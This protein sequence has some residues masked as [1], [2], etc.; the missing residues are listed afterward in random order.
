MEPLEA[1]NDEAQDSREVVLIVEDDFL[2]RWP[3]A[4][5]LRDSGYRVIEAGTAGEAMVVFSSGTHVDLVFSDI[6]LAPQLTGYALARWLGDNHP[7][8][9]VLLTS[10][11]ATA[12]PRAPIGIPFIPKPYALAEVDERIKELLA[13]GRAPV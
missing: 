12:S 11:D 13:R 1:S 2:I 5:Y 4:E 9:P 3:A 8:V 7:H 10:G 6:N